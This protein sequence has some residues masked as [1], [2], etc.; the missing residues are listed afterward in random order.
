MSLEGN[1]FLYELMKMFMKKYEQLF[2]TFIQ[3]MPPP[4]LFSYF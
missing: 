3:I 1:L 4:P 2:Y